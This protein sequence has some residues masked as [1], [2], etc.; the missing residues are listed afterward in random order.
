MKKQAESGHR[1]VQQD[2]MT[3]EFDHEIV[4]DD[5]IVIRC[6]IYRPTGKGKYPAILTNGPYS[7]GL[8]FS[9]G[10]ANFWER[11]KACYPEILENTTGKYFNWETVDPEKWVPEGYACV[12]IDSRGSGRS[13]GMIDSLSPREIQDYYDCIEYIAQLP[14]CDGNI[15]LNGISYFGIS[16]MDGGRQAASAP[17]M[18]HSF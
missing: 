15:G 6:D 17:E 16:Q 7:K 14:W 5:G 18:H 1:I 9:Q 2:E 8:H 11:I 10:Y 13:E 3:I 12:R 4:M